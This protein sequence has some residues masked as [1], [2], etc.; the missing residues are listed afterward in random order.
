MTNEQL[1]RE[2]YI[3]AGTLRAAPHNA[4]GEKVIPASTA[5]RIARL[6]EQVAR[7]LNERKEVTHG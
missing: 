5:L 7:P 6:L 2:A 3:A 4:W 1:V